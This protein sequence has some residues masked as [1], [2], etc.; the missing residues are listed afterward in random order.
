MKSVRRAEPAGRQILSLHELDRLYSANLLRQLMDISNAFNRR[1]MERGA[2]LG[3]DDLKMSFATVL[4]H[5][6]FDNARLSDIAAMNGLSKQAVSQ[7]A[8]ELADLGYIRL[9]PDHEDARAR[10][11]SL[12]ARGRGLIADSLSS[13]DAIRSEA[14]ELIGAERMAEFEVIVGELWAKL[15]ERSA[16]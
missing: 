1:L 4:A 7:T 10:I 6:G 11:I 15:R 14:A 16:R 5:A 9:V 13:I 3:H 12:T 2:E 8:R